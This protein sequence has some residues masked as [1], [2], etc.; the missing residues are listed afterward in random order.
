MKLAVAGLLLFLCAH[1]GSA[2]TQETPAPPASD[3][4]AHVSKAPSADAIIPRVRDNQKQIEQIR[5]DYI[6]TLSE[7]TQKLDS[8]DGVK[9][10]EVKGYEMFFVNGTPILRQVSK[11]GKTLDDNEQHKEQEKVD[12]QIKKA[13]ERAAKRERDEDDP[14]ALG[15]KQFLEAA[16][17]SNGRY[18]TF[19]NQRVLAYD[20]AP[21]PDFKPHTRAESLANKLGGTVWIDPDAL[22]IV[23]LEARVTENFNVAGGLLGSLKRGSAVVFEQEYVNGE[24]WLP[25]FA[26]FSVGARVLLISSLHER[27]IDRFSNYRKFRVTSKISAI[28]PDTK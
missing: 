18:D 5:K 16:R 12:K 4:S 21:N 11:D 8:K 6:C 3:T 19:K 17:F 20:F 7:E 26:D 13:R 10:T 2:A 14:N 28:G 15:I 24:I 25:S 1:P 27:V 23:R 22:Q 9:K